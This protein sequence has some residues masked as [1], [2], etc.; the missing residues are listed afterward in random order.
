MDI[1]YRVVYTV[2]FA[3]FQNVF[4]SV[5]A[6]SAGP[7][8]VSDPASSTRS[9][10]NIGLTNEQIHIGFQRLIR[11]C[12]GTVIP[13]Q[14]MFKVSG[15]DL[16]RTVSLIF[17]VTR[18]RNH[19]CN[20]D[21]G[22][23]DIK[24]PGGSELKVP[25]V[26]GSISS[27]NVI[28]R[29]FIQL[30]SNM[31]ATRVE[32]EICND[33]AP[34]WRL[35]HFHPNGLFSGKFIRSFIVQGM[36]A[37]NIINQGEEHRRASPYLTLDDTSNIRE[38]YWLEKGITYYQSWGLHYDCL[39]HM[40]KMALSTFL[41]NARTAA[42]AKAAAAFADETFNPI[43]ALYEDHEPFMFHSLFI[44]LIRP[45]IAQKSPQQRQTLQIRHALDEFLQ[46]IKVQQYDPDTVGALAQNTFMYFFRHHPLWPQLAR[47]VLEGFDPNCDEMKG[48][49]TDP[50]PF[51]L[52]FEYFYN[53]ATIEHI[54]RTTQQ[55]KRRAGSPAS[56]E[57]QRQP[58]GSSPASAD[59][60]HLQPLESAPA[61]AG[62][63]S[64]PENNMEISLSRIRSHELSFIAFL[65]FSLIISLCSR[66]I[67]NANTKTLDP[68]FYSEL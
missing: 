22:I 59:L 57:L 46:F 33:L 52:E 3:L 40:G 34:Y 62:L 42:S 4:F 38:F 2:L 11:T 10:S 8:S 68:E 54:V 45:Y 13:H 26:K 5:H 48:Y 47:L 6:S 63:A 53:A 37:M 66:V 51:S 18:S 14:D 21:F 64:V 43:S 25:Q 32:I 39:A 36:N 55:N 67:C 23:R 56:A 17:E 49:P 19:C 12:F 50:Q 58:S 16:G 1:S 9:I 60:Q 28:H 24:A 61:V 41:Q 65:S 29:E 35:V 7:S 31:R 27:I 20:L 30:R 44:Q 15:F